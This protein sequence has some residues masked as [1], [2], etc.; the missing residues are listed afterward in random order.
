MPIYFDRL[1]SC[2]RGAPSLLQDFPY[3]IGGI[4]RLLYSDSV[5][6]FY[7]YQQPVTKNR[8]EVKSRY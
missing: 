2:G 6:R 7:A 4:R 1:W 3:Q 5:R 8:A